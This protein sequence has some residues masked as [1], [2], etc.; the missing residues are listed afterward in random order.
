MRTVALM[1]T[2]CAAPAL[3]EGQTCRFTT[4]CYE[5]EACAGTEFD[6]TVGPLG[7]GWLMSSI[8][9][10]RALRLVAEAGGA[11]GFVSDGSDGVIALLTVAADG[12]AHYTEHG[13]EAGA[14][15]VSYHGGCAAQ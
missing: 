12:T 6:I 1:L 10:E 7:D 3:A 14:Y 9:G 5:T 11:R 2:V 13:L 15:R 4:E 8:A